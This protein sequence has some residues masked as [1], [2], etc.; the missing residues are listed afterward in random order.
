[1]SGF[2]KKL[3]NR[4]VGK[5]EEAPPPPPALKQLEAPAPII[6]EAIPEPVEPQ[7]EVKPEPV[8]IE[9]KAKAAPEPKRVEAKKPEPKK[10]ELKKVEVKKVEPVKPEPKKAEPKKVEAK[11]PEPKK[12]EPKK[13]E[14]K[15]VEPVKKMFRL[16]HL[17]RKK[18]LKSNSRF[19]KS[20]FLRCRLLMK[21]LRRSRS[22]FLWHRNWSLFKPRAGCRGSPRACPSPRNPSP[23][24]SLRSSPSAS[25]M[26]RRLRNWKMC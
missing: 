21:L 7:A 6:V 14:A 4:I 22:L 11:K 3:F 2:F 10:P 9:P 12:A 13:V 20:R 19:R 5:T 26:R 23:H 1:M 17:L 18:R 24:R 16:R 8:R 25:W 15:K